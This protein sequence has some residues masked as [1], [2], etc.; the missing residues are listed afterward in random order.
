MRSKM[1]RGAAALALAAAC[2]STQAATVTLS[3]WAFGNGNTVTSTMFRGEAGGFTGVLTGAGAFDAAPFT[4]YCIELTELFQFSTTPVAGY[5]L[6]GGS[7][8]FGSTKS[9]TLGKLLTYVG[10]NPGQVDTAAE[11]TS[12]QLAIWNIVYDTDFSVSTPGIFRD[13]SAY[14]AQANV[15]LAGA[16]SIGTSA[17]N[18]FALRKEGTQ[19]FLLSSRIG[20]VSTTAVGDPLPEP[21]S[22]ALVV[23]ALGALGVT[24][25]R[26]AKAD[27]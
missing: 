5:D 25:R 2:L 16:Q 18:V 20:N 19:D 21:A 22:A 6:V 24:R 8:Y 26:S 10:D 3:G 13:V 27:A 11:S 1:F 9:D 12:L 7:A 14:A 15:L 23:L 17:Y 4:T